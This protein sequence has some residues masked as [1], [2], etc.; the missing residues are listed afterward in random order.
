MSACGRGSIEYDIVNSF[1]M[2]GMRR[3]LWLGQSL[4]PESGPGDYRFGYLRLISNLHF[5]PPGAS[6]NTIEW[7][8][9]GS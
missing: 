4:A 6:I 7:R 9:Q 1:T 8:D 5:A 2:Y 3:R